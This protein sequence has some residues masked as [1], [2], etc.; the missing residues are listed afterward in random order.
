MNSNRYALLAIIATFAFLSCDKEM[1]SGPRFS[2][3]Y[4]VDRIVYTIAPECKMEVDTMAFRPFTITNDTSVKQE[5]VYRLRDHASDSMT[6]SSSIEHAFDLTNDDLKVRVPLPISEVGKIF[7]DNGTRCN[8][9][10]ETQSMEAEW[11]AETT[12]PILSGYELT[13]VP[14]YMYLRMSGS[15]KLYLKGDEFGEERI[16]DGAWAGSFVVNRY[17]QYIMDELE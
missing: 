7:Y 2:A 5:Y 14:S 17:V 11:N 12:L 15:Y 10:E 3:N 1:E 13:I 6:F 16:F 9:G 8:Y 4:S